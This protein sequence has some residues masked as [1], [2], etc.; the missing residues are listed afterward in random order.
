MRMDRHLLRI[1]VIDVHFFFDLAAILNNYISFSAYY[2]RLNR[3]RLNDKAWC[4]KQ[5]GSPCTAPIY[6]C[7]KPVSTNILVLQTFKKSAKIFKL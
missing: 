1:V 3:H 6:W 2:S 7:C 4:C 5:L